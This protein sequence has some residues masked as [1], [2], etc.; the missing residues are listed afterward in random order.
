VGYLPELSPRY[1]IEIL[2]FRSWS[3][4]EAFVGKN[5]VYHGNK[6]WWWEWQPAY[7][8]AKAY[9]ESNV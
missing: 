7:D 6:P 4:V 2:E 8:S 5:S 3:E 1:F 9:F